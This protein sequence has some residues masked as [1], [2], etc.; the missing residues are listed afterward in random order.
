MNGVQYSA[1]LG[2]TAST[3]LALRSGGF[4]NA[5]I[6]TSANPKLAK[7]I[8]VRT[9]GQTS[10]SKHAV[11]VAGTMWGSGATLDGS[12]GAANV[13]LECTSCHDPHGNGNYRILKPV[14]GDAAAAALTFASPVAMTSATKTGTSLST[15]GKK[16][17]YTYEVVTATNGFKV[18]DPVTFIGTSEPKANTYLI[19]TKVLTAP[20]ATHF[21]FTIKDSSA[22]NDRDLGA[23]FT[24]GTIGY[25]IPS[26]VAAVSGDATSVTYTTWNAH[27]LVPNQIVTISGF[28]PTGYNVTNGTVLTTPTSTTFTVA[29]KT[30]AAATVL[31]SISGMPDAVPSKLVAI[32][33]VSLGTGADAGK[34]IYTTASDHGLSTSSVAWVN[35]MVP[36]GYNLAGTAITAVTPTTFT[37]T[38]ATT[39]SATGL[40]SV[41][42]PNASG[43]QYA[44]ANYWSVDD[45]SSASA[46]PTAFIANVSQWCSTCHTRYL[47]GAGAYENASGDST[48]MFRHRSNQGAEGKPNCI[49]CHVAHGSNAAMTADTGSMVGDPSG[50][51]PNPNVKTADS[52]LLRVDNRVTCSFCHSK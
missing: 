44:T 2:G 46:G 14:G 20:D 5:R 50:T 35:G 30:T 9:S 15:D 18:T 27:G 11:G 13:T 23:S 34:V 1:A 6:D 47:A 31:G 26:A 41:T 36:A 37:V 38:N 10:T 7:T 4:T 29:N 22:L 49:Q 25:A 43:R 12:L 51:S 28:T 52:R 8:G 16:N 21:T 19:G 45:H 3:T 40:G 39:A 17:T 24:G 48:F 42:V 33:G 32:T